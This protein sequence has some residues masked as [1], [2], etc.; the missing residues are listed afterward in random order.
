M[1]SIRI[2]YL[3]DARD[4]VVDSGLA[5]TYTWL[6]LV[7]TFAQHTIGEKDGMAFVAAEYLTPDEAVPA[8]S[9]GIEIVGSVGRRKANITHVTALV[10][11]YDGGQ[12][13]TEVKEALEGVQHLGYTSHSHLKDGSTPKFRVV[14]PLGEPC[15][16]AEW[17]A[18]AAAMR[19]LFP[20]VDASTVEGGRLFYTPRVYQD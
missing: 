16:I 5:E 14:I 15:P 2:Q 3:R 18:R 8:T 1:S 4:N 6:E 20:G 10:L 17:D 12:Q 13:I 9:Q 19:S 7:E 11:D